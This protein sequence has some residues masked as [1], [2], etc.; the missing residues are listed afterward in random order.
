MWD[1]L[2]AHIVVIISFVFFPISQESLSFNALLPIILGVI[3][4]YMLSVFFFKCFRKEDKFN[5]CY[6]ILA[7]SESERRIFNSGYNTPLKYQ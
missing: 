4:P 3:V 2:R 5:S 6:S 7:G 1:N